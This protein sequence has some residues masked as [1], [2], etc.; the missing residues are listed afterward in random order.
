MQN[1]FLNEHDIAHDVFAHGKTAETDARELAQAINLPLAYMVATAWVE[2]DG[3]TVA[4]AHGAD[5]ALDLESLRAALGTETIRTLSSDE[6][7]AFAGVPRGHVSPLTLP[8]ATHT[9]WDAALL[10]RP[11]L[12]LPG[13]VPGQAVR[14]ETRLLAGLG[15]P[16]ATLTARAAPPP[17]SAYDVLLERGFLDRVSD[18]EKA[19]KHLSGPAAAGY[20]GF[21]PTADSLHA[22]S[23]MPIMALAHLQRAG[24]K[25][26]AVVG[27]ATGMIGDPSGK[28]AM[29]QF[30]TAADIE[31]NM[32][33]ISR[34]L[35]AYLR[36]DDQTGLL[37]DNAAW[38][39]DVPCLLF[40]RE[41][42]AYFPIR[43]ML[44]KEC[45]RARMEREGEGLTYLE[46]TYML[47]QAYDFV[48]LAEERHCLVQ[49]GGSD[50]WGNICAGVELGRKAKGQTLF[51]QPI[52]H[53]GELAG[54]TF[55]LLRNAAGGKF[56]KTE[57]GNV[58]LDESKTSA[59]DF[60]QFWRNTADRD[61]F[62]FLGLFTF[63]PMP[64][65]ERLCADPAAESAN[66]AKE[67][68][69]FAATSLAHG[70]AKALAAAD[71]ARALFG[72][73]GDGFR[74]ET[75][76]V[77]LATEADFSGSAAQGGDVNVLSAGAA[78]LAA[79]KLTVIAALA[80][81]GLVGSKSEARRLIRQGGAYVGESRVESED[82]T[83]P[84]AEPGAD[85]V[86]RAGKKKHGKI[87]VS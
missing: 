42:G 7:A 16:S 41:L 68:L 67:I 75:V 58:W 9:L 33:G 26:I 61:L 12:C 10:R 69:A 46:L 84:A 65:I 53:G 3:K 43:M 31:A 80:E 79:G 64:E 54:V 50:Q 55:S 30:L 23:L 74:N 82:A 83:V 37:L 47:M 4:V 34:Q 6:A 73:Y 18:E 40:L 81:L 62:R 44:N 8:P 29:R 5:R 2:A 39:K 76:R 25:A 60:F 77:G 17:D 28:T 63:L 22:G 27:G 24:G 36:L 86:I 38:F 13:P 70:R 1:H 35:S 45:F 15:L 19:R 66:L 14:V 11:T 57:K 49:M 51:S 78:D 52:R 21:D 87:R 85:I 71:N 56:G 48:R 32:R 72:G 20:I 59:Y